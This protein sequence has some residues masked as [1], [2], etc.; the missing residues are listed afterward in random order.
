MTRES[1]NHDGKSD[2]GQPLEPAK[3]SPRSDDVDFQ[4]GE[5]EWGTPAR[6]VYYDGFSYSLKVEVVK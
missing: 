5:V 6:N 3:R 4:R 1:G 2:H